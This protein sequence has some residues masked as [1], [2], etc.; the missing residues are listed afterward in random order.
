MGSIFFH[1]RLDFSFIELGEENSI[2]TYKYI[3]NSPLQQVISALQEK[4]FNMS[5]VTD[6]EK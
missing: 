3:E 5:K 2:P 6:I 1:P 4:G